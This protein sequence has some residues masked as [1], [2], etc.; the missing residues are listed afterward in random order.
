MNKHSI[1]IKNCNGID[2][3]N[4]EIIQNNLNIKYG[5][6]GIGK[7]SIAEAI[8]A[9]A[10]NES[11]ELL[12]PFKH[13]T[14]P[15]GHI[16]T[17]S[18][19]DDINSVLVFNDSYVSQFVFQPDEVLKNSFD[20]F[21]NTNEFQESQKTV[22]S[23]FLEIRNFFQNDKNIEQVVSDFRELSKA[24]KLTKSGSISKASAGSKALSSGNNLVHI[25]RNLL[26]YKEF[27]RGDQPAK[28]IAWQVGGNEYADI[29]ERC[30]Y[31]SSNMKNNGVEKIAKDI[32]SKYNSKD[33][34]HLSKLQDVIESLGDY[35]TEGCKEGLKSIIRSK[36]ALDSIGEC[37]LSNVSTS[38]NALLERLN[39]IQSLST[40]SLHDIGQ[41]EADIGGLKINLVQLS[42]LDSE[43][44]KELVDIINTKIDDLLS[45]VGRLKSELGIHKSKVQ[46][47]IKENKKNIN[48]FLLSAGYKYQVSIEPEDG[49]YKMKLF[50]QD[51]EGVHLDTAQ[52][53]LSYGEKNA[54]A[55]VL[56]MHQALS[57]KPDLVILD[58]PVSSF[59][60][61][62][63]FSILHEI[64]HGKKSFSDH[65]TL[66]LTH[67]LE[68]VIDVIK[69]SKG[70][71]LNSTAYFLS[72][73]SSNVVEKKIESTDVQ[74]FVQVCQDNLNEDIDVLYKCIYLRRFLEIMGSSIEARALLSG[75]F[76][77]KAYGDLVEDKGAVF[78]ENGLEEIRGYIG[79]F[80]YIKIHNTITDKE[81][82]QELFVQSSVGYEKIQIYRIFRE[83]HSYDKLLSKPIKE[84]IDETFHVENEYVMQLNPRKF[85]SVP[86][87]IVNECIREMTIEPNRHSAPQ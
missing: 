14:N 61:T 73:Q 75:I 68:P 40:F 47:M 83:I 81:A 46:T 25:P 9:T 19:M 32:D 2:E 60:K 74:S 26:G 24:F 66:M 23:Y 67:D 70:L 28:W 7:S 42:D 20:I 38:V 43:K 53:H 34:Q 80:D 55:L 39:S 77:G 1:S 51:Y 18:G 54:F 35:F 33:V 87:Y 79:D 30:P 22:E 69:L 58:D 45:N 10:M 21:I 13:Q 12:T 56:F 76:H 63:K 11:L 8:R 36:V 71:S 31:C 37:F 27:L 17:V 62:K 82:L 41:A 5:Q 16:P 59:D 15:D 6:N 4:I 64:F 57:E 72:V 85:D 84:F 50:H 29:S 49:A 78:V 52:N 3:A 48:N 44:T 65:T 86:E